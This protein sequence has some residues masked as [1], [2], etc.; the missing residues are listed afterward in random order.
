MRIVEAVATSARVFE[1]YYMAEGADPLSS[2]PAW[3]IDSKSLI[4][5]FK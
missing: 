4:T 5:V 3:A 2:R 1:I